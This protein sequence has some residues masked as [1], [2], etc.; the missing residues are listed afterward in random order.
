MAKA[1][2]V[3]GVCLRGT[4]LLHCSQC[5]PP[6]AAQPAARC[7]RRCARCQLPPAA[8]QAHAAPPD[9]EYTLSMDIHTR[10]ER[11]VAPRGAPARA[12]VLA[13]RPHLARI[14]RAGSRPWAAEL[15]APPAACSAP[16]RVARRALPDGGTRTPPRARL[17]SA[18]RQSAPSPLPPQD[19]IR[20][21]RVLYAH[22]THLPR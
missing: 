12:A 8:C 15:P 19:A 1:A 22:K 17:G 7:K 11:T 5:R 10:H 18:P 4:R 14:S 2:L 21:K 9:G 20:R 16:Q 13:A 3:P 6:A